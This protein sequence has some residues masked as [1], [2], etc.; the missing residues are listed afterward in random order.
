M[1]RA[2]TRT[3]SAI[4]P[5]TGRGSHSPQGKQ[6]SKAGGKPAGKQAAS[7]ALFDMLARVSPVGIF[8]TNAA[9]R[10]LYVNERWCAIAGLS[11]AAARGGGWAQALHPDDRT[12]V[13][14]EWQ[15]AVAA[16]RPF[17][18]EYRFRRADGTVTWVQGEAFADRAVDGRLCGHVGTITDITERK[19]A[20]AEIWRFASIV[21]LSSDAIVSVTPDRRVAS[22][23]RGAEKLYGF[24]TAEMLGRM[25]SD[26]IPP[27][28]AAETQALVERVLR[29]E[30]VEAVETER[31]RKDGTV[32]AV[33]LSV[34]PVTDPGG[35]VV[36]IA[37]IAR[38]IT[39]LKR[40]QE[41]LL[42]AKEQAEIA[43]RAKSTFL[44]NMSHELRT[45]LNAI[46]GFS[47]MMKLG[48][49]GRLGD[50][51]Y[52]GYVADIHASGLHLLDI[53]ND[54]LDLAKIE[55][56]KMQIEESVIVL[57][58][59]VSQVARL[60]RE[61]AQ[62]A[63]VHLAAALD[64]T[65]PRLRGDARA[66]KQILLNL[67]SNA[68]KFTPRDGAVTIAALADA[69]G[70]ALRVTD[71]GIGIAPDDIARLMQPFTQL[72]TA[73]V[74]RHTGTGLGLALVQAMAELHGGA[75]TIASE[76]GRGTEVAVRL[77]ASRLIA[78]RD[79]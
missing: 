8:R 11:A 56:G 19:R 38:D 7:A 4:A 65:L 16:D 39:A 68:I 79:R 52:G 55:A 44:A 22:W 72:E 33:A 51:R 37:S 23:N 32:V 3:P 48:V 67:V 59:L 64:P 18:S 14:G 43:N 70:L 71:T 58:A 53:I 10:C 27:H 57:D 61:Q 66:I 35:A 36:G 31:V 69:G 24:T 78:H 28:R 77:P 30:R 26:T 21:Q 46:V 45:P 50:D 73:E 25:I 54:L 15:A 12:R 60:M 62:Q 2:A 5:R 75:V 76:P 17:R 29:G 40:T 6:G 20:E 9:G 1:A 41:A 42:V 34:S 49:F 47:E 13:C 63:G 74:R